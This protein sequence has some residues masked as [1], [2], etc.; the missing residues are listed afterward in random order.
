MSLRPGTIVELSWDESI[1]S[2]KEA[3]DPNG[4]GWRGSTLVSAG[5]RWRVVESV[6]H[7]VR[8][9]IVE[10]PT[11]V[12]TSSARTFSIAE[13]NVVAVPPLKL[14]AECADD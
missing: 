10:D 9:Y 2:K 5:E 12:G 4:P 14:L 13:Y 7:N 8:E 3:T 1:I 6:T 11:T